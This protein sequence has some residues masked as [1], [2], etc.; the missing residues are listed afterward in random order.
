MPS[1]KAKILNTK[2][3]SAISLCALILFKVNNTFAVETFTGK[4]STFN[5]SKYAEGFSNFYYVNPKALKGGAVRFGSEGTFNNLNP[6]ILKGISAAG[7]SYL[8]DSLMEGSED[9]ISTRYG[10]IA[11]GVKFSSNKAELTFKIR[12]IA[13]WQDGKPITAD[14]VV[15]TFNKLITEGH[16]LYK[17]VYRDVKDVKKI[18]ER[19]VKF[20]F[21]NNQNRD[22]PVLIASMQILPKHY[23]DKV[24]FAK[25]T[26][27]APLGSGPYKISHI[28]IGKSITYQRDPNYW[29]LNLPVNR[30]RYNFDK[31]TF[32]YYRDSN[33]LIEAFKAGKYDLR[34]ENVARNWAN[35]YNIDAVKNGKII[36][37]EI[38]NNL[39]A[40][41]QSFVLNLRRSKFQ[42]V[43]LR[44]ALTYAFDFEWLK[45]HIFYGAYKRTESYFPNSDFGYKNFHLPKSNGDGFNRENLIR[46]KQILD[47]AGYKVV[48]GK[49]I[50]P[51]TNQQLEIEFLIDNQAFQ[52]ITAPFVKNLSKLGIAAKLR[53]VEE[54]QYQTRVN[55][56]D[57]DIIVAVFGQSLIPG[58]ELFSYWHSSQKDVKGGQNLA[59]LN[60]KFVDELVEKISKEQ[61][62]AKLIKLCRNLDQHLLENY[63]T[64]LQYHSNRYRI[65]YRDIFMMPKIT[66]KYSLSIDSW[67]I[68]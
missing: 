62:K 36:K 40:P 54:N 57:Y 68:K 47:A 53:F 29:A 18:T 10:L 66:P 50:D 27:Q 58:N 22:L 55:N 6:F 25:T 34:Q 13:R 3:L 14:D 46:A 32:D 51:K 12:Q 45:D 41:A 11:E 19:E 30:G 21:K 52:M 17:I 37:K 42:N 56:F 23:F 28:D 8:Y 4:I 33:V 35:A 64:I 16:P 48:D 44:K 26:L 67:W 39:P 7:L 60:D 5:D 31:I 59:G 24:D 38:V 20:I 1:L 9:E 2:K 65:L 61:D 43:E 15:F 49:L 63:Y